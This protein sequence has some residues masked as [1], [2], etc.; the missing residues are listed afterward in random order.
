MVVR[1]LHSLDSTCPQWG[2][3]DAF[4]Y[5]GGSPLTLTGCRS[6]MWEGGPRPPH[7]GMK[8]TATHCWPPCHLWQK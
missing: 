7:S 1:F 2:S 3:A 4:A 5:R 8:I 6:C